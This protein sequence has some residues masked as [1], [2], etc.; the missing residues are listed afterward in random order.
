MF[1]FFSIVSNIEVKVTFLSIQ[2]P[3]IAI[4]F[5][6]V[7]AAAMVPIPSPMIFPRQKYVIPAVTKRQITSNPILILAYGTFVISAT[8]LG[9]KSVGIIGSLHRLDNAIPMQI[10][11]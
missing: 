10:I 7:N 2:F 3:T 4:P 1:R 9:N 8:S 6:M 11:R 5:P